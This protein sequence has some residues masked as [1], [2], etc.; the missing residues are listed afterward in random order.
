MRKE[1][2]QERVRN[3]LCLDGDEPNGPQTKRRPIIL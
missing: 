3:M 2:G 1:E